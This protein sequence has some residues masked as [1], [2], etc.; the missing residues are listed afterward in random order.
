MGIYMVDEGSRGGGYAF[1]PWVGE[2]APTS[3]LGTREW[4]PRVWVE[5]INGEDSRPHV[6]DPTLGLGGSDSGFEHDL[7][8]L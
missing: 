5:Y 4:P 3:G 7:C 1:G 2:V 8:S 6:W